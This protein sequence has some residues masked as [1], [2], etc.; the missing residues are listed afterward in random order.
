[1]DDTCHGSTASVGDIGHG[2]GDCTGDGYTAE[3]RHDDICDTLADEFGVAAGLI[4]GCTIGDGGREEGFD[5]A[6]DGDGEC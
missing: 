1:M 5:S 2:A 4:T 3:E 6:E